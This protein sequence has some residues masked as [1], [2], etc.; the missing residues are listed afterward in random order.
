MK[1]FLCFLFFIAAEGAKII[2]LRTK[3][4]AEVTINKGQRILLRLGV[5]SGTGNA[6]EH[7]IPYKKFAVIKQVTSE[8]EK[9]VDTPS[10][11]IIRIKGFWQG[12]VT[13]KLAYVNPSLFKRESIDSTRWNQLDEANKKVVRIRVV[14]P[15]GEIDPYMDATNL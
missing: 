12:E 9:I 15:Y 3:S 8:S 11:K 14:D 4:S 2:D 5:Q 10:Q 1:A 6:W 13:I 7:N